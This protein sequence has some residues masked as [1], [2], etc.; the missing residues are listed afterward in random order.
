MT[1]SSE[2][3]NGLS[4]SSH[5]VLSTPDQEYRERIESIAKKYSDVELVGFV[6]TKLDENSSHASCLYEPSFQ[7]RFAQMLLHNAPLYKGGLLPKVGDV[8]KRGYPAWVDDINKL[9]Q[10]LASSGGTCWSKAITAEAFLVQ[11]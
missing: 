4:E 1:D 9:S 11:Q 8:L 6:I 3:G 5:D 10:E 2:N 7:K